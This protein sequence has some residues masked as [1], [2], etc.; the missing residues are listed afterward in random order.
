MIQVLEG[1]PANV[2]AFVW[3]SQVTRKDCD[4]VLI[5]AIAADVA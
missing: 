5:P 4:T 3:H 1:F 2:L